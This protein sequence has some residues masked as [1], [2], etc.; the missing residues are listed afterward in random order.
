MP[1]LSVVLVSAAA[2][3]PA[4]TLLGASPD[5]AAGVGVAGRSV[6]VAAAVGTTGPGTAKSTG[7][8]EAGAAT[9]AHPVATKI[10]ELPLAASGGQGLA[11]AAVQTQPRSTKAFQTLGVSWATPTT[12]KTAD[13]DLAISVRTHSTKGWSAWTTLDDDAGDDDTATGPGVRGGTDPLWVGPSDGVQTR[14]TVRSGKLPSDL[15][16]ELVDPGSSGYDVTAASTEPGATANAPT[17]ATPTGVAEPLIL[18]RAS[19]GADESKVRNTPTY[20]PTIKAAVLHHTAGPNNYTRSQVPSII[21]GDYAYH[22]SRGWSDIGYNALVDRFGRI[23]EGRAGGLTKAVMGAHAGG[24]NTDTFG[25]SM[26]GNYDVKRP[27]AASITAVTRVMAWKL[28]LNHRNPFGTTQLTSAGGGTARYKAG[29]THTFPVIMGHRNTGFTACPGRYLYPYLPSIRSR[30][31]GLMKAALTNPAGPASSVPI[32][33]PV[34]ITAR[35]LTAQTW[36]LDVIAPCG[37]GRIAQVSGTAAAQAAIT[38]TWNGK[39]ADG[40]FARPGRYTLSLTSR[41]AAGTARPVLGS[42]LVLP[43]D[44]VP[45]PVGTSSTGA[46]GYQPVTPT[47]LLDTRLTSAFGLGPAGRVDVPVLGQAGIP[48]VGVTSVVLNLTATCVSD[49]TSLAVWPTGGPQSNRPVTAVPA[50]ATRSVLVTVRVGA[51][52][53]VSIGN[54]RGVTE[55]TADVV[56][57]Y[58][59]GGSPVRPIDSTRLYDSRSDAGAL[60]SGLSRLIPLPPTFGGIP[61]SQIRGLI[62]NASG[63]S[64]SGPGSLAVFRPGAAGDLATLAY[65]AGRSVDNLAM[66]EVSNGTIAVRATGTPVNLTLD[67]RGLVVDGTA[68]SYLG[69][70][71]FTAVKPRLVVDTRTTGGAVKPGAPRKVVI[72]G[73]PGSAT[74]VLIDL[75]AVAPSTATWL[76]VYPWGQTLTP[77]TSLRMAAGDTRGNLV[78]VPVGADRTVAVANG[79]GLTQMRIDLHGYFQ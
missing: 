72:S 10:V 31:A 77:G 45:V 27:T 71:T 6:A 78:V 79:D 47:R 56:G 67:V 50:G 49:D 34:S 12:S 2:V 3:L 46:G 22:L 28:D 69:S 57:Y 74:A 14:I 29:T 30:V 62:V 21:R 11:A 70:G 38:A 17:A 41:S 58:W 16:L 51:N 68:G 33:T 4:L 42:V 18:S 20:M 63:L 15:K 26:I 32:G 54:A 52:G 44:P 76:Q 73:L 66:V 39:L 25:V 64:P 37:A 61:S 40:S 48:A 24:F 13:P 75:T 53:A 7:T 8:A 1:S 43:P 19:W 60:Q 35:V 59:A 65:S 23:W 36:Q 5:A 55:L 9:G